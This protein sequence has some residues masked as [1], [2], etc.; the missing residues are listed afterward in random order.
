MTFEVRLVGVVEVGQTDEVGNDDPC[1][2]HSTFQSSEARNVFFFQ[3]INNCCT[4][5]NKYSV[6][7]CYDRRWAGVLNTTLENSNFTSKVMG[8][9]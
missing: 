1:K 4:Y 2:K 6:C 9:Y 3:E 5:E 7:V 8:N